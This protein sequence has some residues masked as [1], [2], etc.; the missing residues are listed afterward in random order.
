MSSKARRDFDRWFSEHY[1]DLVEQARR[2]H[3]DNR[4]LVH[5]TYLQ[6]INA[7]ESNQ[8]ILYNLPGYFHTS[9]WNQAQ[10][11]FRKLYEITE[12]PT[13]T[14]PPPSEKRKP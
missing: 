5:H 10:N 14:S 2:L 13:T 6:C 12:T 1:D 7:L 3:P 9:M 11:L 4:D 8:N